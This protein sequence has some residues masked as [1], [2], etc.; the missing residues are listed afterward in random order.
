[1][2]IPNDLNGIELLKIH[3]AIAISR[4]GV[5]RLKNGQPVETERDVDID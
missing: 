5:I 2:A 1:M 4:L 3:P